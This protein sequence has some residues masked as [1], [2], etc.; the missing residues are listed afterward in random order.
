MTLTCQG[1][2]G[3]EDGHQ[4][5]GSGGARAMHDARFLPLPARAPL[6]AVRHAGSA[7]AAAAAATAASTG[8]TS[9]FGASAFS[10]SS[11]RRRDSLWTNLEKAVPSPLTVSS[12]AFCTD[13]AKR[14]GYSLP[15]FFYG[16]IP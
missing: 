16:R 9:A 11:R 6:Q 4:G 2:D 8:K 7:S 12:H 14:L 3:D 15:C 1:D 5:G 10:G 13:P